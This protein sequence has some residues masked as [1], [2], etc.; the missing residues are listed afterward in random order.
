MSIDTLNNLIAN[1]SFDIFL[2][3]LATKCVADDIDYLSKYS[4]DGS[5]LT[6]WLNFGNIPAT[7]H[8]T[9]QGLLSYTYFEGGIKKAEHFKNCSAVDF[10]TMNN[11]A[12]IYLRDGDTAAHQ[13]WFDGLEK[14]L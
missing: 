2:N 9:I 3:D 14:A 13:E 5:A 7:I 11:R 1:K 10:E 4:A 8:I 12:F 6:V